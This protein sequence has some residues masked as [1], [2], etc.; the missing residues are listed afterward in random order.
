MI[1]HIIKRYYSLE[2]ERVEKINENTFNVKSENSKTFYKVSFGFETLMPFCMCKDWQKHR[3]PCKHM[4]AVF[5]RDWGWDV[6]CPKYKNN[7]LFVLDPICFGYGLKNQ[8][9][10]IGEEGVDLIGVESVEEGS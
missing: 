8:P 3:L 2:E 7:P 5:R 1:L 4:C 10:S 9:T 6:L